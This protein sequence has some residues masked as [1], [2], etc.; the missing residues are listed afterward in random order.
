MLLLRKNPSIEA[1][2]V[3]A[4]RPEIARLREQGVLLVR[5]VFTAS[6][7]RAIRRSVDLVVERAF[8]E[9]RHAPV[10]D[11]HPEARAIE[12]DLLGMRDLR[13]F[14]HVLLDPRV[15]RIAKALLGERVTYFGDSTIRVGRGGRG[16]HKDFV[17]PEAPATRGALRFVLYLQDH[18]RTSG[19][20]K[21]RLG[22]HRFDSRHLG[23]MMNVPTRLGDL[24]IFYLRVSH[25]GHN[26]RLRVLPELCMHPKLENLVPR[27]AHHAPSER[28]ICLLW[29]FAEPG[30]HIGRYLSWITREPERWRH[31]GY[32]PRLVDLAAQQ[33]VTL[34]R[35]IPE[36]GLDAQ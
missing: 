36:H 19:G 22:S 11:R 17:D 21:V 25:T 9:G 5:D 13:E 6:E 29:T 7:V 20:L 31:S 34:V 24:A 35:A 8:R 18:S 3:P 2:E 14:C 27:F 15:V 28:R 26:V 1:I 32:S 16:F 23:R 33:G 4:E 30:S 12:G 10:E